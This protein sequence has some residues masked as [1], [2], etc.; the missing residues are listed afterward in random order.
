[1]HRHLCMAATVRVFCAVGTAMALK[2]CARRAA[3]IV[4]QAWIPCAAIAGGTGDDPGA[5]RMWKHVHVRSEQCGI[6][7]MTRA[8]IGKRRSIATIDQ[9]AINEPVNTMEAL[10]APGQ[11]AP[12]SAYCSQ[13]T[14]A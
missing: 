6:D 2:P 7:Q 4:M 13:F 9:L 5:A 3:K 14:N 11:L 12:S 1:M 8:T 10:T